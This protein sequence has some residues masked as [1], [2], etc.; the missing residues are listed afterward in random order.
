MLLMKKSVFSFIFFLLLAGAASA[1]SNDQREVATAV[2]EFYKAMVSADKS[3]L[4]KLTAQELSY[5]HSSGKV[6]D[7]A[8]FVEDV[9]SGAFDFLTIDAEDQTITLA[10]NTAIVRHVFTSKATNNGSPTDI[11]IGVMQVWQKQNGQWKLL[12]RQAF[13]L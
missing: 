7:R 10:G 11:R 1:Q 4:E 8:A 9:V 6:E 2:E 3:M 5:G 12:A 13:K